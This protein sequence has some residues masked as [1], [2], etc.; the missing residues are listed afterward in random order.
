V[1][2]I[3]DLNLI[4]ILVLFTIL[5]WVN[6]NHYHIWSDFMLIMGI[7]LAYMIGLIISNTLCR[8]TSRSCD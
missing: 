5:V 4:A 6:G 2:S 3:N 7:L 1:I 8:I